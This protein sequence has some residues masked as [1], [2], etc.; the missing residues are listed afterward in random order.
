MVKGMLDNHC[1]LG[2]NPQEI[3][4]TEASTLITDLKGSRSIDFHLFFYWFILIS[5]C[6]ISQNAGIHL[7]LYKQD[8][9]YQ[10]LYHQ[11]ELRNKMEQ[12][13]KNI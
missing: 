5:T 2:F 4:F 7:S 6:W 12:S 1:L 9:Q 3:S 11:I 8:T 13:M 10:L